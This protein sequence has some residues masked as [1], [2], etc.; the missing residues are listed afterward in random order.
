MALPLYSEDIWK[1]IDV[2][3]SGNPFNHL[4]L[5]E[6]EHGIPRNPLINAGAIVVADVLVSKLKNPKQEF[7]QY[8]RN[9]ANDQTIS[10]QPSKSLSK[11]RK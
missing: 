4:S 2:E 9:L 1:R 10:R 11:F 8:V 7:L 6:L 5:L 3:P